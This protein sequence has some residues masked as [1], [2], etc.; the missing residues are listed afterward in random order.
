M[1]SRAT[2]ASSGAAPWE[3]HTPVAWSSRT[4]MRLPVS[5]WVPIEACGS[6]KP[7][8]AAVKTP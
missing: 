5:S 4:A 3:K 1:S 8:V 2:Q 7:P 6:V